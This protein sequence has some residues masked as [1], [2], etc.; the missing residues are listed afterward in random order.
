MR[1]YTSELSKSNRSKLEE[2]VGD[3]QNSEIYLEEDSCPE[4]RLNLF[5]VS[6]FHKGSKSTRDKI[7]S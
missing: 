6:E 2:L 4:D 7:E 1:V 3:E 5:H